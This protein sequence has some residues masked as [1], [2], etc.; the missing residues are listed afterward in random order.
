MPGGLG[1]NVIVAREEKALIVVISTQHR[2]LSIVLIYADNNDKKSG[3]KQ[4]S[5]PFIGP[6]SA[7]VCTHTHTYTHFIKVN[8]TNA[9]FIRQ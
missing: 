6:K 5:T 9:I 4:L 2:S 1:R 7:K 8:H 3:V